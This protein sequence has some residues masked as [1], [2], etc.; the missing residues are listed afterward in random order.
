VLHKVLGDVR[1]G[2][3]RQT[4]IDDVHERVCV[5][6]P[7]DVG[8]LAVRDPRRAD[9]GVQLEQWSRHA[10]PARRRSCST[11]VDAVSEAVWTALVAIVPVV[12]ATKSSALFERALWKGSPMAP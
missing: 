1:L 6:A 9:L 4:V 10:C 7:V 3:P 8:H 5:V 2:S 11:T 12:F